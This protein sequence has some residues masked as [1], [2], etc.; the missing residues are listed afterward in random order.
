MRPSCTHSQPTNHNRVSRGKKKKK[1]KLLLISCIS[2]M[3]A[4]SSA[5]NDLPMKIEGVT[6]TDNGPENGNSKRRGGES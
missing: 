4:P 2:S 3:Y 6:G 5:D 1:E